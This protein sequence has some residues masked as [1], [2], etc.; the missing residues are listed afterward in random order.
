MSPSGDPAGGGS[1]DA[2]ANPGHGH[3]AGD[4]EWLFWELLWRG[5][6]ANQWDV[7]RLNAKAKGALG[8]G[9]V[10]LSVLTVGLV[11]FGRILDGD[12]A[13]LAMLAPLP[14]W[15][16]SAL[17]MLGFGG[18][19]AIMASMALATVALTAFRAHNLVDADDFTADGKPGPPSDAVLDRCSGMSGDIVREAQRSHIKRIGDLARN[20]SMAGWLVLASQCSLCAGL[21]CIGLM[22]LLVLGCLAGVPLLS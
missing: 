6:A 9:A 22:P 1:R 2:R 21:A 14:D 5:I 7:E 18:L 13:N 12:I 15:A 20:S 19:V 8:T 10:V 17:P 16:L 11:G 3:G 4:R